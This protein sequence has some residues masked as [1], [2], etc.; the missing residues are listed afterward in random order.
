MS[1][2]RVM[3]LF[4]FQID[5]V[6]VKNGFFV[7]QQTLG[8][9]IGVNNS[10]DIANLYMYNYES[11]YVDKLITENEIVKAK[12]FHMTFRLIDD[13][14]SANNIYWREATQSCAE[15]GG[16]YPRA[17]SFNDTTI[18]DVEVRFLGM[19]F[20][21]SKK[22]K[23]SID[24]YDKK[25]D[26]KFFVQR[27]P[28]LRSYIPISIPYGVFTGLLHFRYHIC[29]QPG[30]FIFR[31]AQLVIL[32]IKKGCRMTKLMRLFQNFLA[33]QAPLRWSTTTKKL[34]SN[35]AGKQ[36]KPFS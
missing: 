31:V 26:F 9:P 10:Q 24:I 13:T 19:K 17:L 11:K 29:S 25:Q 22:R 16:M 7:F 4:R 12:S 6:F 33:K 32:F 14:L 20:N 34:V 21:L 30:T 28:D 1:L 18:S 15:E 3:E 5:N 36:A 2:E 35:L 23:I 27:Y 8:V